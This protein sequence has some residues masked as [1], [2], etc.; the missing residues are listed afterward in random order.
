ML[1]FNQSLLDD[2]VEAVGR[3]DLV[4]IN[5]DR[6]RFF[7][8][9]AC[10]AYIAATQPCE[11]I[12]EA[13]LTSLLSEACN[14]HDVNEAEAGFMLILMASAA[15]DD[16]VIWLEWLETRMTDYALSLSKGEACCQLFGN[17]ETLQVFFPIRERCFGRA[18]K[19]ASS[20]LR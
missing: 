14:F 18:R 2:V 5:V 16:Q 20:A 9:L 1:C 13:V 17:L 10:A 12:A 15:F 19:T 4:A 11:P 3:I 7:E 6:E 8:S